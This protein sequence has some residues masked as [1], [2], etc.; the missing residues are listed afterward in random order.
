MAALANVSLA[1]TAT[2]DASYDFNGPYIWSA[3]HRLHQELVSLDAEGIQPQRIVIAGFS[4]GA[5]LANTYLQSLLEESSA[6]HRTLLLPRHILALSGT[7][8]SRRAP[9]ASP[10]KFGNAEE[11]QEWNHKGSLETVKEPGHSCQVQLLCGD[12]DRHF[13]TEQVHA[14]AEELQSCYSKSALKDSLDINV[15][16]KIENGLPHLVSPT[17]IKACI[18]AVTS[19][20][21]E[22]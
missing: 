17:M 21:S 13:R 14:A 15:I 11:E 7:V 10:R 22:V 9:F 5:I 6:D 19:V 20:T 3:L 1:P 2:D 8:F 12:N 16:A 4:Q 18:D